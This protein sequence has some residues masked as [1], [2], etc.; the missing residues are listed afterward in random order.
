MNYHWSV[1]WLV[2]FGLLCVVAFSA[3]SQTPFIEDQLE[4]RES[5]EGHVAEVSFFNSPGQR[6]ETANH[7]LLWTDSQTGFEFVVEV[8]IEAIGNGPERVQI[9]IPSGEYIAVPD[10]DEV[11]DSPEPHIFQIMRP[12]F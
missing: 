9:V 8:Y 10:Y 4:I 7:T 1:K 3:K 5:T 6:S 2:A 12:M 11:P